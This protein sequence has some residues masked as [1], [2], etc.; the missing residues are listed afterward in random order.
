MCAKSRNNMKNY[1]KCAK[2]EKKGYTNQNS[3]QYDKVCTNT[4][5]VVKYLNVYKILQD[6]T[7][8]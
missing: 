1:E 3:K 8:V 7:K 6:I 5:L 2:I 4:Q